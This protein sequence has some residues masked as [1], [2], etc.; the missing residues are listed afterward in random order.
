M[1]KG[2]RPKQIAP[3]GVWGCASIG[4]KM[5]VILNCKLAFSL[6]DTNRKVGEFIKRNNHEVIKI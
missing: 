6:Q 5:F 2:I 3:T 1:K 4:T